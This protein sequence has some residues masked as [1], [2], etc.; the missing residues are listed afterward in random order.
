MASV[1]AAIRQIRRTREQLETTPPKNF[2]RY[3]SEYEA[4]FDAI[5]Q[6]AGDEAFGDLKEWVV[7]MTRERGRLPT[8][9]ELRTQ[10]RKICK[11]QGIAI[12]RDSPLKG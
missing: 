4:V 6:L 5:A 9:D 8:P 12:P 3:R 2:D 11:E 7:R 10:A 1:A